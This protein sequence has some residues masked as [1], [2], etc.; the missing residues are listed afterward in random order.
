MG[1]PE[2]SKGGREALFFLY[3]REAPS[4]MAKVRARCLVEAVLLEF[5]VQRDFAPDDELAVA[6]SGGPDSTAL[7]V[8]LSALGWRRRTALH[9]DHGIRP[10]DE[11]DAERAFVRGICADLGARLVVARVR[12]GAVAE[13]ARASGQGIE[14]EARRFRYQ[15]LRSARERSGA[16]AVLLAHTRDDQL[17]TLLMRLFGGSGAGGL[18]G[19]PESSGPFLRPFLGLE[20]AELLA[21]LEERGQKYSTDSTNASG[22]YLRNRIRHAMVPALDS[23]IPGWRSGLARAAA[24]AA[25]DEEAL[26]AIASKLDFSAL[27]DG[28]LTAD[29]ATLLGASDAIAIRA[30][31]GVA[32]RTLGRDRVSSDMA[33]AALDAL[34]KSEHS[35]YRGMGLELR[36]RDGEVLLRR[37]PA[38][39]ERGGLDFPR[40][41]GYFVLIDR[42]CRVR[43]G[44]LE[45]SA[46]WRSDGPGIRADTFR[47][48]LVVRSR[49]PGDAIALKGGT[50]RL[51]AL[52][53]EWGLAEALRR[54][55]AVVEDRDGIV[56]VLGAEF[57][58]KDR[59]RE[60]QAGDRPLGGPD[61][62][63]ERRF[64]VIVKGA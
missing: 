26:M 34:R 25:L 52:F 45:V 33:A 61:G 5:L 8:A 56:A 42:P 4:I 39:P 23:A 49:R 37:S 64:S 30:I 1:L 43:I 11:L 62:A 27:P 16:R 13:R 46:S 29:A 28:S 55:V 51:D 44:K 19:I 20:K 9:V 18:K 59:F 22:E 17:E 40:R 48:P 24:K 21:Y 38:F 32:G 2:N 31:V 47:F 15:A 6:Y 53:S 60:R 41:D 7:L 50:K 36:R 63:S 14:A 35:A 57:G 54:V 58:G 12:P 3:R 10:R